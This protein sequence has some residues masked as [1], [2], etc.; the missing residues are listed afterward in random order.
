[1]APRRK[2]GTTRPSLATRKARTREESMTTIR[3]SQ[4]RRPISSPR[5]LRLLIPIRKKACKILKYLPRRKNRQLHRLFLVRLRAFHTLSRSA[6]R[7]S[8]P[9]LNW[10]P[11]TGKI[12]GRSKVEM[13]V[14]NAT[15][16]TETTHRPKIES[17]PRQ[18]AGKS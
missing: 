4:R 6:N 16:R 10:G 2:K 14:E 3:P 12:A 17:T 9:M 11:S 8:M 1:M 5:L 18:R 13:P 7:R 15:A